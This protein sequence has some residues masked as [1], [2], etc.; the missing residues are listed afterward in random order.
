MRIAAASDLH[1]TYRDVAMPPADV[2]II[3]GDVTR[4]GRLDEVADFGAW[5]RTLPHAVKI[6][7]GGNHDRAMEAHEA[8]TRRLLAP[9]IYLRD[10][11]CVVGGIRFY[12]SPWIRTYTGAFNA[13]PAQLREKWSAIPADT[14][15]LVT[16]MPPRM[17]R[18]VGSDGRNHG[19]SGLLARV[20]GLRL[21]AH[22]FG[23][24]HESHGRVRGGATDFANVAIC[25]RHAR[26]V[27]PVTIIDI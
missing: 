11:A 12:G 18:D 8:D 24:I 20:A 6:V 1:G 7:I 4:D 10:E 5:L 9:A 17:L 25:D 19:E 16:H 22:V 3:A 21:R 2:L 23:H 27:R 14:D 15:V 26:P 13:D